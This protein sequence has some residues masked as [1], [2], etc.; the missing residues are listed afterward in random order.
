MRPVRG[1]LAAVGSAVLSAV[2]LTGVPATAQQPS[3]TLGV[4]EPSRLGISEQRGILLPV[5]GPILDHGQELGLST[6][7]VEGL[8]R[9]GVDVMREAIRRQ[10]DLMIAQ[11]D[12]W[13]L[14]D[15]E[16]DEAM[17]AV[18]AEAK[19]R[20][21]ARIR[22]DLEIALFRA[23]EAAKSQ[24]TP[25]QRSKLT[26]VLAAGSSGEADPP[27]TGEPPSGARGAGHAPPGGAGSH[28]PAGRPPAGSPPGGRHFEGH[29][30]FDHGRGFIGVEPFWWGAPYPYSAYP[31]D[32]YPP[33]PVVLEPPQYIQQEPPAYWY[34]C[35]SA[36]AYY[37]SVPTCPEPWVLVSPT[38]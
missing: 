25:D 9:L 12:L 17:D 7:Q 26:A 33:P 18:S 14:L 35:P 21:T 29:R 28:P 23:I 8:E 31:E 36:R 32:L 3:S 19:I 34:Y 38:G 24:L 13:A 11:V 16:P 10:A 27:G 5:V 4:P 20:E 2:L 22:A 30:Q 1:V 6:S 15:R 37:P